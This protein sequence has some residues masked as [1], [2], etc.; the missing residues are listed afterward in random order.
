MLDGKSTGLS[1]VSGEQPRFVPTLVFLGVVSTAVGSLGA[2][3]LETVV[4]VDHVSVGASQWTLTISLL[5]GAVVTP[6]LGRIGQG[7]CRKPVIVAVTAAVLL[8]CILAALPTG[9]AGL[10]VGRGLQ[11]VGLA[12]VP[13]SVAA[14][15]D[16]LPAHRAGPVAALLGVTTAV[17]I[18]AG[19]PIVG[20]V[21]DRVGMPAA[22]WSG[23]IVTA[24]AL[25][26][27]MH[28][29]P[30]STAPTSRRFDVR[31]AV[32][33]AMGTC[34][35]L[36]VLSEGATW[37]WL[38]WRTGAATSTSLMLLAGWA[39]AELSSPEPLVDLRVMRHR[40]VLAANSMV[41]LV[42]VGIYP[43]L[44]LVVRLIQ[45]PR[46]TG[47][48]FGGSV[49][50]AGTM[51]IPF[52][53]ASF[54]ASRVWTRVLRTVLPEVVVA[55]STGVLVLAMTVFLV[56]R[57]SY[58]T[59]VVTMSLAGAGVGGVFAANPLQILAGAPKEETGSAMSV[60][61]VVR[62][63]GFSIG[64]ALS[65][66]LLVGSIPS[67]GGLPTAGGYTAASIVSMAVLLVATGAAV[68]LA[69][70]AAGESAR[71]TGQAAS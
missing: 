35:L 6:V 40:S 69:L 12:I 56:D 34:A 15:R 27:A 7:Y 18:G 19:Y 38:T 54:A 32:A 29:V 28:Y 60:Y 49:V 16:V 4:R 5:V 42:G 67:R 8:G 2:P 23:A 39:W 11:G 13:L 46:S 31:G 65:A 1:N 66:T 26:L 36:I 37:G 3:L 22:F 64:S 25:V 53:A 57:S 61:Q 58:G 47:Y 59:I 71:R 48:G 63:V 14:A 21:T 24:I 10:L 51:L 70:L 45:A 20:V 33:L 9:F 43:L 52:S 55:L 41:F 50:V 17:G 68:R 44:S 30:E 62:S